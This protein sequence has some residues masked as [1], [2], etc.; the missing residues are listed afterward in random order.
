MENELLA[1]KG[2]RAAMH[3]SFFGIRTKDVSKSTRKI[4]L[5]GML[6]ALMIVFERALFIP[7]G[8]SSRYSF[9]F[10]VIFMSG[11]LLGAIDAA[12][13]AG[14]ADVIGCILVGYSINPM[15][16]GCVMLAAFFAGLMLFSDRSVPKLIAAI[17][18]EQLI[19]NLF[20]KTAALAIW[21]YGGIG[22]YGKVFGI[23]I[24]QFAI[25]L[26]IEIAVMLVLYRVFFPRI[27]KMVA[28]FI[29]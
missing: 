29:K 23:R 15:I 9:T 22:S 10:I 4:A 25:M 3:K 12:I 27:K 6:A 26:P 14:I 16:T 21:F 19:C 17:V 7:V 24:V 13:V 28:E 20:I 18:F 11:L 5:M 2:L 1:K 8:D